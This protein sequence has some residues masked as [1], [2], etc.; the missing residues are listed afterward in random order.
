MEIRFR[1]ELPPIRGGGPFL[2]GLIEFLATQWVPVY[3]QAP[4]PFLYSGTIRY[5]PEPNRGEYEEFANPRE[6]YERGW[7]DCDDLCI[8][9]ICELLAHGLPA[10]CQFVRRIG[11]NR[12]HVRVR[13]GERIED[14]SL[15]L[16][17]IERRY[18]Q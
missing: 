15:I 10:S 1:Y 16:Q 7:G 6:V 12:M 18:G 4:L 3:R 2:K 13:R 5:R 17:Q 11:T 9:R 8:Y 14:P